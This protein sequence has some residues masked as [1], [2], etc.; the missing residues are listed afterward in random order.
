MGFFCE[1]NFISGRFLVFFLILVFFFPEGKWGVDFC[2]HLVN[3]TIFDS[4]YHSVGSSTHVM[5]VMV[6]GVYSVYPRADNWM[7]GCS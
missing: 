7:F 4:E 1:L 2:P 6:T 5:Y 3:L